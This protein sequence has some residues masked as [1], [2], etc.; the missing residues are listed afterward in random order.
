MYKTFLPYFALLVFAA[1]NVPPPAQQDNKEDAF[2]FVFLTDI[3]LRPTSVEAFEM[4]I[5][6][7]NNMDVDFVLSGGDQV[8][9]VL[10]GNQPRSDSLFTLVK[11]MTGRLDVPFYPCIGNHELFAI[12]EESPEDSLHPDYKY[13]MYERYFGDTYYSFDHK[14]WHFLVLNSLD[15]ENK[16]YIGSISEEQL[17]W[18][19]RDLAKVDRDTPIAVALHIPMITTIRQVYPSPSST[20]GYRGLRNQDRFMDIIKNHNLRL[21]LQ[22]HLHWLED[23]NVM[24][25]TR[26]ITGGAVAGRPSWK[27][28]RHGEEGFLKITLSGTDVSW[29]FIDYGWDNPVQ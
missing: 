23:L 12:Y 26:Y 25:K 9:D 28:R 16:R 5:D 22:G 10:R 7:V 2:S 19:E 20:Q 8:Y 24:G 4:V 15:A 6:T 3:H 14:G 29:D 18:L 17:D 13:G 27:G 21:V 1:C 11:T